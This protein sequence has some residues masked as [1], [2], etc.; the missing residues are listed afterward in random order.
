MN[1]SK[2]LFYSTAW[3]TGGNLLLR[4]AN[5]LLLPL[6]SHFIK[7]DEFGTLSLLLAVYAI[8][9]AL[10]QFGLPA[11]LSKFYL[12]GERKENVFSTAFWALTIIGSLLTIGLYIYNDQAVALITGDENDIFLFNIILLSLF[13]ESIS[14]Y[15]LQLLKTKEKAK[16]TVAINSLGA[17]AGIIL[18]II[19]LVYFHYGISAILISQ[20]VSAVVVLASTISILRKEI[21]FSIDRILFV[22]MLKFSLPLMIGGVLTACV[23]FADR[24]FIDL[25]M[26]K[27]D[28]GI[29]S[30]AYR[31]ALVMN[32]FVIAFRTAWIPRAISEYNTRNFSVSFGKYF[33]ILISAL[34]VIFLSIAFFAEF[35]FSLDFGGGKLFNPDYQIGLVILQPILLGYL[36]NGLISFFSVY[37]FVSGKGYHF[38][39]ADAVSFFVNISFNLILI[40]RIGFLG[41]AVA[42]QLSFT[43]GFLYLFILSQKNLTIKFETKKIF[44]ITAAATAVYFAGM[45]VEL[46]HLR[47]LLFVVFAS[48][49]AKM[50][51][52]GGIFV[53]LFKKD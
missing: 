31:I 32:L 53:Q 17:V 15:S 34:A 41:A 22:R 10:Y 33:N 47:L 3:Y 50:F 9:S 27:D 19:L 20:L 29:Y 18:T 28:V 11:A 4:T 36:F 39:I 37:P 14:S 16:R 48:V 25:Y 46:F 40:P 43:F 12:E 23:D 8:A 49:L 26:T 7:P 42:T 2:K 52:G 1:G 51:L 24:F 13:V 5:F 38:L 6:Y 44:A 21:I 30:F 35:L 45:N